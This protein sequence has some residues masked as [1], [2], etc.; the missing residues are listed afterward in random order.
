ME[1]YQVDGLAIAVVK[2]NEVLL[3]KGFGVDGDNQAYSSKSVHGLYS[4][5]KAIS[6]MTYAS[7]VEDGSF[8]LDDTLGQLIDDAPDNW[9]SIPFW[10]LLNH[11]SGITMIVNQPEFE[12]LSTDPTSGN[13]DIY[14]W[15][16]DRPL[17]Y[18]P[19]HASRYRQSGYGVAEMIITDT[20]GKSWPALVAEHLTGPSSMTHTA[21]EEIA[22]GKRI[23]PLLTSAGGF[24]TTADDMASLFVALNDGRIV[25]PDFL[26]ELLFD[27]RYNFEGYSLGSI[28][29]TIDGV[30]SVG[31]QGGGARATVRY[32]PSKLVG[33]ALMTDDTSNNDM[34]VDLAG[35]LVR[36]FALGQET[37]LPVFVPL[38]SLVDSGSDELLSFFQ[39][40]LDDADPEY[41][42]SGA[43]L[44]LNR[45]GYRMLGAGQVDD[46]VAVF[47]K[48]ASEFPES[49]NTHDSLGESYFT[50]GDNMLALE[51]YRRVLELQPGNPNALAMIDQIQ[52]VIDA[53]GQ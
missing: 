41:D 34:I 43:E 51:S 37:K 14:T 3:S 7:I 27:D 48:N 2:G 25:S 11:T 6:S 30:K 18:E 9:I 49:A 39:S 21:P 35:M 29:E 20:L 17:D 12:L 31:H 47:R 26:T 24:Q 33:V 15:L 28:L 32:V 45:I 10:R 4:A 53:P 52:A 46:A 50:A 16:R 44:A 8:N 23:E 36:Q 5:T 1:A 42:L 40:Q 22:S 38:V 13:R 19:G